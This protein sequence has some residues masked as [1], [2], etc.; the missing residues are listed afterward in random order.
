MPLDLGSGCQS[1]LTN[2]GRMVNGLERKKMMSSES[3]LSFSCLLI[4]KN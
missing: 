3:I 2:R 4:N 1:M